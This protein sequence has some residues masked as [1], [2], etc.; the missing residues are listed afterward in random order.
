MGITRL[1]DIYSFY[2]HLPIWNRIPGGIENYFMFMNFDI[3]QVVKR[4][5][6]K[7]LLGYI[8]IRINVVLK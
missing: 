4:R 6:V 5:F 3:S 1:V 7:C 2:M 8:Y